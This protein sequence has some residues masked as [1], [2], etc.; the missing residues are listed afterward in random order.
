ME[1]QRH[2]TMCLSLTRFIDPSKINARLCVT[3]RFW[4]SYIYPF[5]SHACEGE[6]IRRNYNMI[7]SSVS[8]TNQTIVTTDVVVD[9]MIPILIFLT[10]LLGMLFCMILKSERLRTFKLACWWGQCF[11]PFNVRNVVPGFQRWP[12][13]QLCRYTHEQ[14]VVRRPNIYYTYIGSTQTA[15]QNVRPTF[16]DSKKR[17]QIHLAQRRA[18][19]YTILQ[20]NSACIGW[21][22]LGA[23]VILR[24]S[25]WLIFRATSWWA[26][27]VHPCFLGVRSSNTRSSL[28]FAI[29]TL[30]LSNLS[31][32]MRVHLV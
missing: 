25:T 22:L 14:K 8:H 9:H 32:N 18:L 10:G 19:Y 17:W 27:T 4:Y 30:I 11:C 2:R 12:R 6:G 3:R 26:H 15:R 20:E 13:I 31:P 28:C 24:F 1:V 29:S 7:S 23:C 21:W 5:V 16:R